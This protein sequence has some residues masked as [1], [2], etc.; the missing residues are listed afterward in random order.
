MNG[1]LAK[2]HTSSRMDELTKWQRRLEAKLG[3]QDGSHDV[4]HAWRVWCHA[5]SIAGAVNQSADLLVLLAAAYLH[6]IV[7]LKKDDPKRAWASR[8]SARKARTL[9]SGLGFPRAK[10]QAVIHAIEAHSHSAR[11]WPKT[12]EARILQ[13]ADRLEALG[14][15]GVARLFYAEGQ[16]EEGKL[17]H[18]HDPTGKDRFFDEDRYAVDHYYLKLRRSANRMNTTPGRAMARKRADM[19]NRF[20]ND[21]VSEASEDRRA[22]RR[23]TSAPR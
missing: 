15:I 14:A 9:L 20:I 16:K 12:I 10:M 17:F 18:H 5:K 1:C 22:Y 11:I 19:L 2:E 3:T 21:L 6:D 4:G 7:S 23:R 13:D 8:L